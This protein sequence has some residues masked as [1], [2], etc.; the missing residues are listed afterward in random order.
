MHW[1]LYTI[2]RS[3]KLSFSLPFEPI[4]ASIRSG[5]LPLSHANLHIVIAATHCFDKT[6]LE[7]VVQ[8]AMETMGE[9]AGVVQIW[10]LSK[11]F[12][13]N[14]CICICIYGGINLNY[15]YHI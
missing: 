7:T 4:L 1:N 10:G 15:K 14:V 9:V 6:V 5:A 13:Y 8:V 3:K 12:I 11:Y 2:I